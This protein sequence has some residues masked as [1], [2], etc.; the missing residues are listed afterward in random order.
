MYTFELWELGVMVICWVSSLIFQ[1]GT[2]TQKQKDMVSE[3][4]IKTTLDLLQAEGFV[5][6]S[7][8]G[9]L[10]KHDRTES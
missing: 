7:K 6:V 5:K 2:L 8:S 10:V 9:D 4:S 3:V 1:S